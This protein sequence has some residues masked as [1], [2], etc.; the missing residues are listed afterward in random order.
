MTSRAYWDYRRIGQLMDCDVY[1]W[2]AGAESGCVDSAARHLGANNMAETF[3]H[4]TSRI[5]RIQVA[6]G[7]QWIYRI[8]C[9]ARALTEHRQ[10]L[11]II[12][13]SPNFS[14]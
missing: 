8:D 12:V 2:V 10:P 11:Y 9:C 4:E 1:N 13:K 7:R 3:F 6:R 5:A 14:L